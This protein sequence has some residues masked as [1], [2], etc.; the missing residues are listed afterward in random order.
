MEEIPVVCTASLPA[1]HEL[2]D[3]IVEAQERECNHFGENA[4]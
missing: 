3:T 1:L 4:T 2:F